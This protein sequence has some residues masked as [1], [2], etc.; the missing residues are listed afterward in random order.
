MHAFW[1]MLLLALA[2]PPLLIPFC[3]RG[4][5]RDFWRKSAIQTVTDVVPRRFR[6]IVAVVY[7]GLVLLAAA[8]LK[9][10]L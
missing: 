6:F 3:S 8:K 5:Q 1:M 10:L 9:G 2:V 4:R 7:L